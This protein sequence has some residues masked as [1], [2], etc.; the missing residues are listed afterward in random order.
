MQLDVVM[1]L[2][3]KHGTAQNRKVYARHGVTGPA[4][5]VSYANLGSLRK[6]IGTD[7]TLALALWKTGNHDA[8]V[9]ACMVADPELLTSTQADAWV[10]VPDN[11][12]VTEAVSG[13]VGRSRHARSRAE[14]WSKSK[15]EW[16][17]T[18]GWNLWTHLAMQEGAL[19]AADLL[20]LIQRVEA[21]IG[22][23]KNR[24]RYA[25]NNALIAAGSC[26][27]ALERAAIATARRIGKVDVDHGETGC[28][29]P[30]AA[31]YIPKAAAHRTSRSTT[32]RT[33]AGKSKKP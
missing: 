29:T 11:Y 7:H 10:R 26:G 31:S 30:D 19:G 9:L 8:Q 21:E 27:G 6:Q 24:V 28:K 14:R 4:F 15:A 25:M 22:Q 13:L 20:A 5:G 16:V 33:G 1:A 23:A 32:R 12:V 2:L 18:A 17:A 3:E